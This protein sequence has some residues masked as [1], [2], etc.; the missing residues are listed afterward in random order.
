MPQEHPQVTQLV[1]L[2]KVVE[3]SDKQELAARIFTNEQ[4]AI[5]NNDRIKLAQ[6]IMNLTYQGE[7]DDMYALR[8]AELQGQLLNLSYLIDCSYR[9]NE[10]LNNPITNQE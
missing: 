10:E 4:L 5:L 3:L 8:L 2:F 6:E 1:S 9:A 7:K